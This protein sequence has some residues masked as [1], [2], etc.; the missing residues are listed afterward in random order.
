MGMF[1][2]FVKNKCKD[3]GNKVDINNSGIGFRS[4]AKSSRIKRAIVEA[5]TNPSVSRQR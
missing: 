5:S 2:T 4:P 1:A 3:T